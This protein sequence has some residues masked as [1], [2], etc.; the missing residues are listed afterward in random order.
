M[1]SVPTSSIL[2]YIE[3]TNADIYATAEYF[4]VSIPTIENIATRNGYKITVE[5][6]FEEIVPQPKPKMND[7]YW[8]FH[9]IVANGYT[10]ADAAEKHN[11]DLDKLTSFTTRA[12]RSFP[13]IDGDPVP[14][15]EG[16]EF[17]SDLKHLLNRHSMENVSGTP[18]FILADFLQG[19][20][21]M[22]EDA[23]QKRGNWRHETVEFEPWKTLQNHQTDS[24]D[25]RTN[26]QK[27]MDDIEEAVSLL[28]KN[29]IE[30][31]LRDPGFVST[32]GDDFVMEIGDG[33]L[34]TDTH[35][36]EYNPLDEYRMEIRQG[37]RFYRRSYYEKVRD[38]NAQVE[39]L[40]TKILDLSDRH[41]SA[42]SVG[43]IEKAQEI[44][45]Q[46]NDMADAL[47]DLG[48]RLRPDGSLESV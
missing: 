25:D 3:S 35:S 7:M 34:S 29:I 6:D 18:D 30:H 19:V 8:A 17:R 21:H 40:R 1:T 16:N 20:L 31:M 15:G 37:F 38:E 32:L 36:G 48:L 27:I 2:E 10:L 42:V 44:S 28:R 47:E 39:D 9:D 14:E 12:M 5:G 13:E 33:E 23:V 46:L 22:Y 11:V 26:F 24:S 4:G 43:N 45:R 41:A